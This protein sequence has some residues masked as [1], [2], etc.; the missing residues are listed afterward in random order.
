MPFAS[1]LWVMMIKFFMGGDI[2]KNNVTPGVYP[3]WSKM[4]LRIWCIGRLENMVLLPLRVMYR[5]APLMAFVLRQ[6]G[7]TVGDNLQC[8]HDADLSGPLDLISIEDDVAIQT[9]AYIQTT[10][11]SG[12]YLH[13]GPVHLESGCKIGMRAAIANNVTVGRGTWITPF[14]P[15]LTDVGSQEIWEGA[16]ARLSG[17]CTELKRTAI[18][19]QYAYPIWLLETLNILMQIFI[20]FWLSVVPTAAIFW[21]ARGLIPA[22]EAELS[23][24]YFRVTPLFEIVWHLTLYAFITT[25]VTI[26]VTSLLG[27][28]F[29]RWTAASPGLYPS[30][31]LRGALLMYR[32]NRMNDIQRLW[33]WTITGQYLRALAGMHF[34]RLGASECDLMFNLVPELATADSQVFFV[35]WM[36][37]EHARLWRRALQAAPPRHAPE[38]LQR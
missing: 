37:H 9:G 7:A 21:F 32:M 2:Y 19:C 18:A 8:A 35:Q 16:P 6:L 10:R 13:V 31:G 34:P 26:V 11:W 5:S 25:W 27:C 1:L 14:T 36:F 17:R 28:L 23:D 4:H 20:S 22:G 29:I 12:Q 30:R 3:K 33:T 38:F 15:I 24:A